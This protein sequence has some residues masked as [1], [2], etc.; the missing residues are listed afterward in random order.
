MKINYLVLGTNDRAGAVAFYQGLFAGQ[1]IELIHDGDR[2]SL[3]QGGDYL[4]ALAEPYDGE[5]AT[6]GN[7]SMLGLQLDSEEQVRQFHE[8]ALALGGV[9]E[10]GPDVRSGRFSAYARDLDGNKLCFYQ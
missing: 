3:W 2:M 10:G 9:D 8:R 5:P 7:G 1:D 6:V 4:F